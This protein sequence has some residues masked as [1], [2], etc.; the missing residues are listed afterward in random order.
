MQV[1][2]IEISGP[3]VKAQPGEITAFEE[4]IVKIIA[5]AESL[6]VPGTVPRLLCW[7]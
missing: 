1:F 7:S 5:S 3:A 4:I 6:S 2:R